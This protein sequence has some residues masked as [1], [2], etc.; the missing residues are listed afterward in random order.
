MTATLPCS[1]IP[2]Y[3]L[4]GSQRGSMK[5]IPLTQGQFTI[6]DDHWFD[7]LSQWKWLARWSKDTKSFY[8]VRWEGKGD[9]RKTIRMSRVIMNTPDNMLCD[10]IHRNTLDNRESELRNVT[11]AQNNINR[12]IQKNNNSGLAGIFQRKDGGKYRAILR[13]GGKKVLDKTF[14][15]IEGAV[16]A[17][18]E[19]EKKYFGEY[20]N[21]NK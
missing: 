13:F 16:Q 20:A 8:A 11:K 17:R 9:S 3:K 19:A 15:S 4:K 18:Q 7:Y 6:V 12:N 1:R 2:Y 5:Q 14:Q 21:Q 10:H